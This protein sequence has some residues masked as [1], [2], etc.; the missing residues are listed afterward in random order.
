MLFNTLSPHNAAPSE[1]EDFH[2]VSFTS[3]SLSLVWSLP[4]PLNGPFAVFQLESGPE[5]T[6]DDDHVIRFIQSFTH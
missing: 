3:S 4:D 1:P 5:E 6:F 2:V